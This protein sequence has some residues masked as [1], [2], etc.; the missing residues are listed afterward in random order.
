MSNTLNLCKNA[1]SIAVDSV[2]NNVLAK[3]SGSSSSN[4]NNIIGTNKMLHLENSSS[5]N[6][7]N[8]LS[9]KSPNKHSPKYNPL[10]GKFLSNA[11]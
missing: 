10:H 7:N 3:L 11:I 1:A 4:N 2:F 9:S 6:N 5:P 8:S